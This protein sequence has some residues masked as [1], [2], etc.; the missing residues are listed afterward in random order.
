M[1]KTVDPLGVQ[2][3]LFRA[4]T[5]LLTKQINDAGGLALTRILHYDAGNRLTAAVDALSQT[6]TYAY[7]GALLTKTT[8]PGG[9]VTESYYDVDGLVTKQIAAAG[10]SDALTTTSDYDVNGLVTKRTVDSSGLALATEFYYN[11][12]GTQTRVK[13][14]DGNFGPALTYDPM[15]RLSQEV[16][17]SLSKRYEYDAAGRQGPWTDIYG[18]AATLFQMLTG[19]VLPAPS[20]RL[21]Q[22]E[23][24]VLLQQ[25]D[26]LPEALCDLLEQALS[27][28]PARRP[29]SAQAFRQQLLDALKKKT[30]PIVLAPPVAQ[31]P[32]PQPEAP[33]SEPVEAAVEE[34]PAVVVAAE[35]LVED[36]APVAVVAEQER[37]AP[38]EE[39]PVETIEAEAPVAV[40]EEAEALEE[41]EVV[42]VVEEREDQA[43]QAVAAQAA[44]AQAAKDAKPRRKSRLQR[45][46]REAVG[47]RRRG[48]PVLAAL[49]VVVLIALSGAH[50]LMQDEGSE[51]AQF[52]HFKAQ[53]D[54]LFA[55]ANYI[56]AKTQYE[57]ALAT[58]PDN[59]YV[60][61]RLDETQQRLA[62][63]QDIRYNQ[64]LTQGEALYALGNSLLN[65]GNPLEALSSFAEANKA[66]YQA[67]L[68]RPNDPI[69]LEKGWLTTEGMDQAVSQNQQQSGQATTTQD[70]Q[71]PGALRQQLY[72]SYRQQ[73]D[74]LF[75]LKEYA[76]AREKFSKALE[77]FPRDDYATAGIAEIDALLEAFD[78]EQQLEQQF[79]QLLEQGASLNE[80]GRYTEARIVFRQAQGLKPGDVQAYTGLTHAESMLAAAERDKEYRRFRDEGDALMRQN[81]REEAVGSYQQALFFKPG[82]AYARQRVREIQEPE[83]V[84]QEQEEAVQQP[85]EPEQPSEPAPNKTEDS[86]HTVVD[87]AP[88]LIGGLKLLHSKVRY[89]DGARLQEIKGRVYVQFVLTKAGQVEDAEVIR[90]IGGGCDEEA[91]RVIQEAWFVPGK[92][93][94]RPV[95]VRHT[96]FITFKLK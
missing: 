68:Y 81:K 58:L 80:Q 88:V 3:H 25:A 6:T 35:T 54:S 27:F 2:T 12:N 49:V 30:D 19:H 32:E 39:E 33:P 37:A 89:P 40:E 57:N 84:K 65:A 94:G 22:D 24:P 20:R 77:A 90:G 48:A 85:E 56:K 61:N 53:G 83:K 91:L 86:I 64:Y 95:K 41:L 96:L 11:S 31:T 78:R 45:T 42:S 47:A 51:V 76:A 18:S 17:G 72:T 74:A 52:A 36:E 13:Y 75:A 70:K 46:R 55:M 50:V 79:E 92:I 28:D 10:T 62:E 43:A 69:V 21:E 34:E 71:D 59:E 4:S 16:L 82:D 38:V 9:G 29:R 8:S 7:D 15:G 87:E 66:F 14:P 44:R 63:V 26:G 23:V 60:T 67:L 73:G 5:G 93:G 1:T